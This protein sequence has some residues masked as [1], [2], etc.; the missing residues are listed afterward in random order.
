MTTTALIDSNY[1]CYRAFYTT[2]DLKFG[3]TRTGIIFGFLNQLLNIG[4]AVKADN[5]IFV[6]D[7]KKSIRKDN[8]SFYKEKR[9]QDRSEDEQE[10]W[11]E[12][13]KQFNKLR[14]EILPE[15]GFQNLIQAGHEADDIIG[16]LS[17]KLN[18]PKIIISSDSDF[19]QLCDVADVYDP[20]KQQFHNYEDPERFIT[21]LSLTGQKKDN[22]L[23]VKTPED[24][25]EGKRKPAFGEK[26]A[27]KVIDK[28]LDEFLDTPIHY[29]HESVYEQ[30][31]RGETVYPRH[32]YLVNRR[33]LDLR[34][35]PSM[36]SDKVLQKYN[37]YSL[38]E[39]DNIGN[40]FSKQG[41]PSYLENFEKVENILMRLY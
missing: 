20:M 9:K 17:L 40:F 7:S 24:W 27:E 13:F 21:K 2:P 6:W 14:K 5:Y 8:C 41:W 30:G 23:N 15:L 31:D 3:N 28:G 16:V 34:Q 18:K 4:K 32:R 39:P 33:I 35:V 11:G 22:V 29:K 25:P 37:R 10:Q 26:M 1:L 12:A 36:I 38:P 19:K